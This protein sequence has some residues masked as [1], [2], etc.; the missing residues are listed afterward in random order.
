MKKM[1]MERRVNYADKVKPCA[2]TNGRTMEKER[3]PETR[4]LSSDVIDRKI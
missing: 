3:L 2:A 1:W 4:I